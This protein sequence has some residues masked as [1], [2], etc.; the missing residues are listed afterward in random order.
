[1]YK[2]VPEVLPFT[3]IISVYVVWFVLHAWNE[4]VICLQGEHTSMFSVVFALQNL[5]TEFFLRNFASAHVSYKKVNL[6]SQLRFDRF[7]LVL[8]N[9]IQRAHRF[10]LRKVLPNFSTNQMKFLHALTL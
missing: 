9:K 3:G 4:F 5:N 8:R 2:Q 10:P 1:M 7:K 6:R